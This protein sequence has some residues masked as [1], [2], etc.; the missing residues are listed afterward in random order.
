MGTDA[1]GSVD[2]MR[3]DWKFSVHFPFLIE[4]GTKIIS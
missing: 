3:G 2:V 1:C 4:L